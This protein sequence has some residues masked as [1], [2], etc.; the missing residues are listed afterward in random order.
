MNKKRVTITDVAR[1]ANV[2]TATVSRFLN[3]HLNSMSKNTANRIKRSISH[4]GYVP[5]SMARRLS[6]QNDSGSIIAVGVSDIED[7]FSIRMFEGIQDQLSKYKYIPLLI[8]SASKYK[9]ERDLFLS[10]DTSL[11]RGA[12]IHP[13]NEHIKDI[14]E[15]LK[16]RFPVILA[17]KS[18]NDGF[19][20]NIVANNF[21]I[22]QKAGS[23]FKN[24]LGIQKLILVT[25]A[26][27][28]MKVVRERI[29]GI[30]YVYPEPDITIV[31]PGHSKTSL[32]QAYHEIVRELKR[33]PNSLIF[34]LTEQW[35]LHLLPRLLRNNVIDKEKI[36]N[37]TGF[38][39]SKI[40]NL[41]NPRTKCIRTDAYKMGKYSAQL[42]YDIINKRV[43]LNK[44]RYMVHATFE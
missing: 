14:A 43:D 18:I 15:L 9:N 38:V 10:L 22:A 25:N 3:N 30:K 12:I 5:N 16:P 7:P 21:E 40:V 33:Q 28:E 17:D 36:P 39:S 19:F 37:I 23:F 35:L 27:S 26:E 20:Y 41:I 29:A 31:K 1:H 24:N 4:L 8:N 6:C 34:C 2:S 44:K 42:M 13:V 11:I 32:N